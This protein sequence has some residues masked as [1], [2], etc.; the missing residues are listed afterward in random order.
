MGIHVGIF[1]TEIIRNK[2][3]LAH[4]GTQNSSWNDAGNNGPAPRAHTLRQRFVLLLKAKNNSPA[5]S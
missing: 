1:C 4:T 2:L 5:S 3:L